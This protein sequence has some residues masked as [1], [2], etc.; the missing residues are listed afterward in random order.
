[1]KAGFAGAL[2]QR[3]AIERRDEGADALGGADGGWTPVASCWAAIAPGGAPEIV[4]ADALS[5]MPRWSVTVR[6]GVDV[7]PGD[8]IN[9]KGRMMAVRRIEADPRTPDRMTMMAEENRQ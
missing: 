7:L 9:W 2:A 5:A 3:I 6:S 8:R 4:A 1:M